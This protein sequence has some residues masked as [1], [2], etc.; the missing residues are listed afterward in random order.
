MLAV[1][2]AC[3]VA[4]EIVLPIALAFLLMLV[5]RPA[6]RIAERSRIPRIVATLALLIVLFGVTAALVMALAAPATGW[7]EKLP[8]ALPKVQE[9]LH[10][11]GEPIAVIQ[12]I[13]NH[14]QHLMDPNPGKVIPVVAVEGSNIPQRLLG[15]VG[16]FLGGLLETI[17]V[18]LSADVWRDFPASAGRVLPSFRNKRQAV[19]ISQQI[20]GDISAYLFTITLMN[21]AVGTLWA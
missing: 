7:V 21:V 2:T 14:A 6:M 8:T 16:G 13:I 4:A 9:L 15:V 1:L 17:V 11:L 10:F 19:E 5:L 20:E 18:L 12:K 3:Y